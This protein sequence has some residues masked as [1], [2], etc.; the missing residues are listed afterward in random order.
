MADSGKG[1]IDD[2][3]LCGLG[4]YLQPEL[5]ARKS[6]HYLILPNTFVMVLIVHIAVIVRVQV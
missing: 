1:G 3:V 5:L 6:G 2:V 4:G